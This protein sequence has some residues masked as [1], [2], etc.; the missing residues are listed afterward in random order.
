M[1]LSNASRKRSKKCCFRCRASS[2]SSS[3]NDNI[4]NNNA[5]AVVLGDNADDLRATGKVVKESLGG[6][7][8]VMI[9]HGSREDGLTEGASVAVKRVEEE[10]EDAL[11]EMSGASG[12]TAAVVALDP[13]GGLVREMGLSSVLCVVGVAR[14]VS[15]GEDMY[16]SRAVRAARRAAVVGVPTVVVSAVTRSNMEEKIQ[17]ALRALKI[18][19]KEVKAVISIERAKNCPRSHFPF[20]TN[21]RWASL[22]TSAFPI[23]DEALSKAIFDDDS[24]SDFAS[25][26]AWSFGGSIAPQT[27]GNSDSGNGKTGETPERRRKALRDAFEEADLF[28]HI[29]VPPNWKENKFQSTRPGV[30]WRQQRVTSDTNASNGGGA[31]NKNDAFGR[32]LPMQS[33]AANETRAD[34]SGASFV[35]QLAT[36]ALVAQ[37]RNERENSSK[38]SIPTAFKISSGTVVADDSHRGDLDAISKGFAAISAVSSW[39]QGHAFALLDDV[40]VESLREETDESARTVGLPS[41]LVRREE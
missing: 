8:V 21:G 31:E 29:H 7:R 38:K 32:T 23:E 18:I 20:P 27:K 39:P 34:E 33:I 6:L 41:W 10:E 22:G 2:S 35:R 17:P 5:C 40:L 36:E 37:R 28:L 9:K 24:G 25:K 3:S 4:V 12:E 11:F 30:L 19:L 26:D 15:L 13:T 14:D 1:R 16:G